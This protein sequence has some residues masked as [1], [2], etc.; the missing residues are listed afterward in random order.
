MLI[1]EMGVTFKMKTRVEKDVAFSDL[2][3]DF[4]AIFLGIGFGNTRQLGIE[5]EAAEGVW[6]SLAYLEAVRTRP[7]EKMPRANRVVVVGAGN[8][9][10]DCATSAARL[11][12]ERVTILYRRKREEVPAF[13]YEQDIALGDEC[14]FV[15]E[16]NPS[17]IMSGN[18]RISG[19]EVVRMRIGEPG[20]DGK[21]RIEPIPGSEQVIEC[22]QLIKAL[23][24]EPWEMI[25]DLKGLELK[26]GC[27]VVDPV[28]HATS[29][30]GVFA[31]GDCIKVGEVVDAVEHGKIA[32]R[33][34]HCALFGLDAN[35]LGLPGDNGTAAQ[36]WH[37]VRRADQIRPPITHLPS[38]H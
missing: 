3:R 19:V 6:E 16:V 33:G 4:D 10:I 13:A 36:T 20:L 23:G 27:V 8:T 9:A 24:Q 29:L 26:G 22:D 34:I 18:G 37:S 17:R 1:E 28:T 7:A 11:G 25:P 15:C 35:V 21:S 2:R 30:E 5:G 38:I 31:G 32:A 12:A 14:E